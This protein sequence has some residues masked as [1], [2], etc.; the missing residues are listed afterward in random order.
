MSNPNSEGYSCTGGCLSLEVT[1]SEGNDTCRIVELP[2][3]NDM[4]SDFINSI[5]SITR[6]LEQ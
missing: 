2:I 3:L 6:T 1:V 4:V 5:I